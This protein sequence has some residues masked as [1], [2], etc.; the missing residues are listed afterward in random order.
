MTSTVLPGDLVTT[1]WLRD[2]L[3]EP[4]LRVIDIRGYVIAT[5]EGGGRQRAT[6][7][8]APDE[9]QAGHIPGSVFVDWTRD[10][11]DLDHDVPAQ[12]AGPE[13]FAN[14]LGKLGVDGETDVV[15]VD[16]AGGHFATRLWWALRFYG[17]DRV[18]I[19]EGGFAAWAAANL[20]TET[21]YHDVPGK[22]FISKP[23][24]RLV[25]DAGGVLA[26]IDAGD[27]QIVDARDAGTFSGAVQRGSRGGH[28]PGAMNLSAR[29]LLEPD[30][31]W[32]TPTAIRATAAAS[33]VD[34]DRPVTAYCNGGV[35]AT[36]VL[37]GLHLAGLDDLSNYDGSW[38]EWGDR[39]DLPVE[40]NRDLW[41]V[42]ELA[43]RVPGANQ[44]D[45][46]EQT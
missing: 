30:G 34:L 11:V 33:G 32:K 23:Q 35:T 29:D 22:T 6:Y 13:R 2:H 36:A 7:A 46:P 42:D 17:H 38:N 3:L 5:D 31:R 16:H 43:N 10:I 45:V 25:S 9:Y 21:G 24:P 8:P 18:A 1:T 20:A 12:I 19:L 40:G 44:G 4:S 37:F 41:G 26:Q 14:A 15:V 28:I 27:R 39:S